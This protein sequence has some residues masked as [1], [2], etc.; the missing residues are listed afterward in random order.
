MAYI[1]VELKDWFKRQQL[2]GEEEVIADK[3]VVLLLKL[4]S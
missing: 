3:I 4:S 1:I 2:H